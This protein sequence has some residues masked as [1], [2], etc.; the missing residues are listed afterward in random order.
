MSDDL[1]K[2]GITLNVK[3]LKNGPSPTPPTLLQIRVVL[4]MVGE[5]ILHALYIFIWLFSGQFSVSPSEV[6]TKVTLLHY[7]F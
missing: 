1:L 6:G 5:E 3:G 4:L 7:F 2:I